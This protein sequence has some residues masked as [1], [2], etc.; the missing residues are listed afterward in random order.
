MT[1]IPK[2]IHEQ[3]C[4]I[5]RKNQQI[6]KI[7]L[8]GSRAIGDH[9]EKSDIDL[10]FVAPAMTRGEWATFTF[11][12]EEELDTLLFLDMVRW[13]DASSAFK[14]EIAACG[15]T[16]YT[17]AAFTN[18]TNEPFLFQKNDAYGN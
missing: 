15:V 16:L 13:E 12:L 7:I 2:K 5:G 4:R 8:F 6:K 11:D 9:E 17:S 18:D 10:A 1:L 14:K 3:L